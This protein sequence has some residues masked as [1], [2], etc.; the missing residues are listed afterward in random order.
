MR[1][2]Y[3]RPDTWDLAVDNNRCIAVCDDPYA[4]AQNAACKCR[5]FLGE[6]WYDTEAGIDYWNAV[7]AGVPNLSGL[8]AALTA[9][10]KSVNGVVEAQVFFSGLTGRTLTGQI[11]VTDKLGRLSIATFPI[12][13]PT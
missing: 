7:L 4:L 1:S 3:L 9:T 11:Q 13:G 5:L 12:G 8:R 2:L 10:A 6:A